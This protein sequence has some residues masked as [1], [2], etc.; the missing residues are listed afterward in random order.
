M[1]VY[2]YSSAYI[3]DAPICSIFLGAG[4]RDP[5]LGP[6]NALVDTGADISVVPINYL[7]RVGA[8]QISDGRA[9]T[10]WGES[11]SVSVY[12]VSMQL[13]GLRLNAFRVLADDRGDEIVLGRTVLNRLKLLL[14]GPAAMLEVLA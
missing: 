11:R 7:R 13:D 9:R 6:L 4:G 2:E 12:V 10:L 14:D 5:N 1:A 8:Q 3:P